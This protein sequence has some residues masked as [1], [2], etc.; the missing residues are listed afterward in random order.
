MEWLFTD[1]RGRLVFIKYSNPLWIYLFGRVSYGSTTQWEK[2]ISDVS[3]YSEAVDTSNSDVCVEH[4]NKREQFLLDKK[5]ESKQ[6]TAERK[7]KKALSEKINKFI[8]DKF[9]WDIEEI[10]RADTTI[11]A[12][13][14]WQEFWIYLWTRAS[15]MQIWKRKSDIIYKID[16]ENRKKNLF[17]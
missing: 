14:I 13:D 9:D 6:K 1:N 16:M 11:L 2:T 5:A 3:I 4:W 10:R 12:N 7:E 15:I 8:I 17:S